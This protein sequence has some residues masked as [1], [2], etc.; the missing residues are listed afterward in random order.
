[1]TFK[2]SISNTAFASIYTALLIEIISTLKNLPRKINLELDIYFTYQPPELFGRISSQQ[3]FFIYQPYVYTNDG[4][5]DYYELNV[6][7]I[8]PDIHIEIDNYQNILYELN[9][10]GINNG[11]IYGDFDNIAKAILKSPSRLIKG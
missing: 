3:S 5:Y 1:M 9:I 4:V 7:S 8:I 10:L 2:S 6:Q 11:T